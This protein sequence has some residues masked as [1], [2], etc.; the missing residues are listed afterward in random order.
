MKMPDTF[1][2]YLVMTDPLVGYEE[3]ARIA[4][5]EKVRV[6]QL[7]M[8]DVAKDVYLATALRVRRVLEGTDSLYIVNDDVE[9]ARAVG[10]DGV[11]L[12]Q[13]DMA[14][15]EARR[16]WAEPGKIFGLSTHGRAQD[17]AAQDSA[18]DYIGVG[19][20]Y[21][22]PTKSVPDPTVGLAYLEQVAT[23]CR[24]PFVA[25]GGIN[26]RTLPAVLQTG[27]RNYA[28]V[29]AVCAAEDP[30]AAIRALRAVERQH[31]G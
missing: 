13:D 18:P 2:L 10:A 12:G 3:C 25:I 22:T 21:P 4:A 8:K 28:V 27:A 23:R 24:I 5:D 16:R 31:T 29:R 9:V 20:I 26:A 11:H 15:G 1:G 14:L 6:V 17:V 30:A 7:R 19:P